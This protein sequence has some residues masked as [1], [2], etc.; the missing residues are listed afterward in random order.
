MMRNFSSNLRKSFKPS[1]LLVNLALISIAA[2]C[3]LP[4]IW[5]VSASL[6]DRNE[7]YMATPTLLPRNPTLANYLWMFSQSDMS[8]LPIN[9]WNSVKV[10]M[11]AVIIQSI[12]ATMAGF[13]FARLQF[14]GRDLIFYL[15]ILMMF[16][17]RAGGLM[18]LYEL[19]EFLDLRNS[20]LG[21]ML[22][23][24]SAISVALFVMRQNFLGVPRELEEAA[25]MDGATTWQLFWYVDVPMVRGGIAVVAIW[26]FVY[27]WGEYLITLTLIDFPELETLA[28][29]VT[30]LQ[31]W[32]AHFTSS[33]L[34]G[35]G[36]ESAA[37]VI[38]MLPVILMFV[39]LQRWFVQGLTEGI[40]KL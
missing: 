7:L 21:L 40:I 30:K 24:P 25:I 35:Y 3:L 9:M 37:Y 4:M 33:T 1:N 36:A 13:A 34:A 31:G 26:E 29:A 8:R 17:P 20:H 14:R 10:T 2:I 39:F 15:L 27:V 23:F 16:I 6:K 28:L 5:A 19:M 38:A 18:A 32:G 22:L 12:V 11:G